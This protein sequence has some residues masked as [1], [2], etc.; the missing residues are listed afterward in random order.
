[1]VTE[2]LAAATNAH[3][4]EALVACFS[5]DYQ[6]EMPL[7]PSR[8]FRGNDQVRKNWAQF[9]AAMPDLGCTIVRL[10][11]DGDTEWSEWEMRGT[12]RDGVP[13]HVR[14]V[15]I[16]RTHA[17]VIVSARFYLEPVDAA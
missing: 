8:N 12:R 14:G 5:P 3:D 16:F 11:H 15:I 2:R 9:F 1:M 7:H 13:F 6:L 10:T 4:L 17:D